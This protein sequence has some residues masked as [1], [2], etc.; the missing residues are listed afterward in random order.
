MEDIPAQ[1]RKLGRCQ[2]SGPEA[3]TQHFSIDGSGGETINAV[4][5][6]LAYARSEKAYS[7]DK[8]G[9]LISF[10]VIQILT[11][12]ILEASSSHSRVSSRIVGDIAN[13]G[14]RHIGQ[15]SMKCKL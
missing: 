3:G 15:L 11:K 7:L 5:V 10:K 2:D 13:S 4:E 1:S 12:L 8:H 9:G 14:H 6:R